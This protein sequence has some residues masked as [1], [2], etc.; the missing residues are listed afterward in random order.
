MRY[1]YERVRLTYGLPYVAYVTTDGGSWPGL[2][3]PAM[4]GQVITQEGVNSYSVSKAILFYARALQGVTP[5]AY[6]SNVLSHRV[7]FK[8]GNGFTDVFLYAANIK[9]GGVGTTYTDIAKVTGDKD[10]ASSLI[11]TYLPDV[12]IYQ[13][14]RNVSITPAMEDSFATKI[15]N[16]PTLNSWLRT[17]MKSGFHYAYVIN[18]AW[19]PSYEVSNGTE[20]V[21]TSAAP[22]FLLGT[23][24]EG[25]NATHA[26]WLRATAWSKSNFKGISTFTPSMKTLRY[27]P[28]GN[29]QNNPAFYEG[30]NALTATEMHCVAFPKRAA[31]SIAKFMEGVPALLS[32]YLNSAT[33][34][35]NSPWYENRVDVGNWRRSYMQIFNGWNAIETNWPEIPRK[36][37]ARKPGSRS[38]N[39]TFYDKGAFL[40]MITPL[41]SFMF[42]RTESLFITDPAL[43]IKRA[44]ANLLQN[45]PSLPDDFN[46]NLNYYNTTRYYDHN[47]FGNSYKSYMALLGAVAYFNSYEMLTDDPS[48]RTYAPWAK[49]FAGEIN[50]IVSSVLSGSRPQKIF[51]TQI[52]DTADVSNMH[53]TLQN[54]GR[55]MKCWRCLYSTSKNSTRFG[56]PLLAQAPQILIAPS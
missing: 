13:P 55:L 7:V 19:L 16:D 14:G 30:R 31:E 51:T 4:P 32:E 15:K 28:Y 43:A 18:S 21:A 5:N 35:P 42:N 9:T 10:A 44:Y 3:M 39:K 52:N 29:Y 2:A 36:R 48:S 22:T 46:S 17:S 49:P 20:A 1:V 41:P 11:G 24:M 27:D 37:F 6:W 33:N 23:R 26:D 47:D 54:L 50:S 25:A 45:K 38:T 34:V 8:E 12:P 56:S 53:K 40:D